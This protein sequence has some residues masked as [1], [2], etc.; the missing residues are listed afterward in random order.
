[1]ADDERGRRRYVAPSP[2]ASPFRD[3]SPYEG[4]YLAF[5]REGSTASSPSRSTQLLPLSASVA[6]QNAFGYSETRRGRYEYDDLEYP[7]YMPVSLCFLSCDIELILSSNPERSTDELILQELWNPLRR[8]RYCH[9]IP[10]LY[11]LSY[12]WRVGCFGSY[13]TLLDLV[14]HLRVHHL[15]N[16]QGPYCCPVCVTHSMATIRKLI[17]HITSAHNLDMP[18]SHPIFPSSGAHPSEVSSTEKAQP[19]FTAHGSPSAKVCPSIEGDENTEGVPYTTTEVHEPLR[20][21]TRT[22]SFSP[23]Y[24][25]PGGESVLQPLDQSRSIRISA[26]E[27]PSSKPVDT[28][29]ANQFP[30]DSQRARLDG[31]DISRVRKRRGRSPPEPKQHACGICG[32]TFSRRSLRENHLRTHTNERPFSC[33]VDGCSEMFKLPNE[34][35]R[36]ERAKHQEKKFSCGGTLESGKSW[37]CGRMFA[38]SDGLLEHQTKTKKGRRCL[39]GRDGGG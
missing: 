32:K 8:T 33:S 36:H 29:P 35:R 37:G 3:G 22:P 2:P 14:Q 27:P 20:S 25:R 9:D 13:E 1:M 16:Q 30:E 6:G 7:S 39:E 5:R 26:S 10:G 19:P 4:E 11:Q 38:R 12:Q 18:L 17:G 31:L 15:D 28:I 24:M 34:Q 23:P 21:Q